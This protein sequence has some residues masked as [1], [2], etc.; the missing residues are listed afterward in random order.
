MPKPSK[1]RLT[2]ASL[3][4][5]ACSVREITP[6]ASLTLFC[7]SKMVRRPSVG[8]PAAANEA[9]MERSPRNRWVAIKVLS[10]F[11]RISLSLLSNSL[12]SKWGGVMQLMQPQIRVMTTS[13]Y[14][15]PI[16]RPGLQCANSDQEDRA[17]YFNLT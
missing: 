12:F 6:D 1:A 15:L 3:D 10:A 9:R 11:C 16:C 13:D 14:G 5:F 2:D 7:R 4:S 17:P 8:A